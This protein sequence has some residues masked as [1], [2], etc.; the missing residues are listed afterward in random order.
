MGATVVGK[1]KKWYNTET[2]NNLF[3]MNSLSTPAETPVTP[4]AYAE[5]IEPFVTNEWR[6]V[7]EV[8]AKAGLEHLPM[9]STSS[10]KFEEKLKE[11]GC[12]INRNGRN[13]MWEVKRASN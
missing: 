10:R 8:Y 5:T 13:H 11:L 4:E 12:V 9:D 3:I 1:R 2:I 6:P 7:H